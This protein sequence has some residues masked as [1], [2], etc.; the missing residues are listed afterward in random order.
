MNPAEIAAQ[1]LAKS[2]QVNNSNKT[3]FEE[4]LGRIKSQSYDYSK[5]NSNKSQKKYLQTSLFFD[6][7]NPSDIFIPLFNYFDDTVSWYRTNIYNPMQLTQKYKFY[8]AYKDILDSDTICELF[9]SGKIKNLIL[10]SDVSYSYNQALNIQIVNEILYTKR[11]YFLI[12]LV[13][14]NQNKHT[15]IPIESALKVRGDN[16]FRTDTHGNNLDSK[17]M[18]DDKRYKI[19]SFDTIISLGAKQ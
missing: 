15:I 7:E 4:I 17:V 8:G 19:V 1:L 11:I 10:S 2:K 3:M 18:E 5:R 9:I 16:I 6:V 14:D 13:I 12:K